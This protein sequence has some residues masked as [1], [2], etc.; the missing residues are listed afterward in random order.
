MGAAMS[1]PG[2]KLNTGT[3]LTAYFGSISRHKQLSHKASVELFQQLEKGSPTA[4][5][6]L[7]E[8]N[9]RLVVSIAK[10]YKNAGLPLEDLIQEG[11]IGLMKAIDKF[12][13]DKGFRFSTYATWWIRQAIGDHLQK[14]K[15][16]IR[17]PAHAASIQRQVLEA[18]N[19]Y[20]QEFGTNPTYE[21]LASIV[22]ASEDIVRATL[23][24]GSNTTSL[25]Q[26]V[27][28]I[29]DSS[30]IG[31]SVADMSPHVDPF[32]N[33]SRAEMISITRGVLTELSPKEMAIL[34]LR[35]GLV[36]DLTTGAEFQIT[37]GQLR[38]IMNGK[39]ME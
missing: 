25:S 17:M 1:P 19:E 21:E 8:A 23:S 10:K 12:K 28:S 38:D 34:R 37:E 24:T 35:F 3:N 27:S 33:V 4:K 31:D 18:A 32:E 13:W 6:K 20:R 39:G 5:K 36:D 14:C 16:T 15:R 29:E 2:G 30:E 7:I 22:D 9:L 11:N 26:P